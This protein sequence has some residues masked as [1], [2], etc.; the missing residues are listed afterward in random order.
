MAA[1][2]SA[3][4]SRGLAS[5]VLSNLSITTS[6]A[7][8]WNNLTFFTRYSEDAQITLDVTNVG[9]QDGVYTAVLLINNAEVDSQEFN[10]AAGKTLPIVFDVNGIESGE[11]TVQ[12]GELQ[13]E[14]TSR[15]WIN[16]WFFIGFAALLI[17]IIWLSI[18]L[19]RRLI[20][21]Y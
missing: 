14:F 3:P 21:G 17:L 19:A 2:P 20:R 6:E 11:Y 12:I 16:W 15:I 4:Q 7:R 5:F 8:T 18:Y 9:E 1:G 10:L 13:G